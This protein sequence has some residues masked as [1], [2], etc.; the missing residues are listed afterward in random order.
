ML[1]RTGHFS[2]QSRLMR[3]KKKVKEEEEEGEMKG[4]KI[5]RAS[6]KQRPILVSFY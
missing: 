6:R 2:K 1:G 5:R 3:K 4:Y